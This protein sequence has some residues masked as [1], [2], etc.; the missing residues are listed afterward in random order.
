MTQEQLAHRINEV[1]GRRGTTTA[2]VS[3]WENGHATPSRLLGELCAALEMGS[4]ELL[5][6]E[7]PPPATEQDRVK[8]AQ[9]RKLLKDED[10]AHL[11]PGKLGD[12]ARL[13]EGVEVEAW[14]AKAA[15]EMLFPRPNKR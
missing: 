3:R 12:L 15:L 10:L 14:R 11:P 7:P 5:S 1:A 6:G 13:L 8:L 9:L 4:D 2:T